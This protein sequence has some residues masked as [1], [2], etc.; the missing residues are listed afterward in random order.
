MGELIYRDSKGG[1]TILKDLS[2]N[3][4]ENA[5]NKLMREGDD[6]DEFDII[7]FQRA[8]DYHTENLPQLDESKDESWEDDEAN[9]PGF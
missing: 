4:M 2:I 3:H 1:M 5:K 7:I 9:E 6:K 8:I